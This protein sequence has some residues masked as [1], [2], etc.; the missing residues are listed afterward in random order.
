MVVGAAA[1]AAAAGGGHLEAPAEDLVDGDGGEGVAV[2]A[3]GIG[4]R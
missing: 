2:R 4:H 3:V 1:A